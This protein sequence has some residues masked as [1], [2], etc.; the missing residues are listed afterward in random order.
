MCSANERVSHEFRTFALKPNL[1]IAIMKMKKIFA[2]MFMAA[3]ASTAMVA[4]NNDKDKEQDKD[5]SIV[6]SYQGNVRVSI[7]SDTIPVEWTIEDLGSDTIS[8]ATDTIQGL[9]ITLSVK[10]FNK[11][12]KADSTLYGA[13]VP[14]E[15]FT[16]QN[17]GDITLRSGNVSY[18]H[19][20]KTN[21]VSVTGT[22]YTVTNPNVDPPTM[23]DVPLSVTL[24]G[25]KE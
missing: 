24:T 22:M 2:M 15:P 20:T 9:G 11:T 19:A 13:I 6:G 7:Q 4:C 5:K 1:N 16:I 23:G 10:A 12:E 18:S 25:T 21:I 3:A 14:L 17:I 8:I